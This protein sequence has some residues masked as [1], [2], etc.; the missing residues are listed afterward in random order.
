MSIVPQLRNAPRREAAGEAQCLIEP[1][2]ATRRQTFYERHLKRAFDLGFTLLTLPVVF[3]LW[4]LIALLIKLDSPGPAIVKLSR[5][6]YKGK[7]FG[8]YK[9]RTMV[10]NAEEVLKKLLGSDA[11]LR[12]E[13][14]RDYKIK[15]DPRITRVGRWLRKF[16]LDELP[17]ALNVIKGEMSWVG[18]RPLVKDEIEKYYGK[19]RWFLLSV[20]PGI[21]GLW[22]VSG[23]SNLPYEERVRLEMQ[24]IEQ[25]SF[26]NDVRILLRTIPVMLTGKGAY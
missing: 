26:W 9:F 22:Q 12:E 15:N 17:Q 6:G 2:V 25:V 21:T 1:R 24:Y 7:S 5:V 18:P 23:R 20:R 13:F 3:P 4:L 19:N 10:V 16:S 14:E 8:L 11:K